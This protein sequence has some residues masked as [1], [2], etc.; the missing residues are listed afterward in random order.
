M[1][2]RALDRDQKNVK[3]SSSPLVVPTQDNGSHIRQESPTKAKFDYVKRKLSWSKA[4]FLH[5]E[6][7]KVPLK[8]QV[9]PNQSL[10]ALYF[11]CEHYLL[12][13]CREVSHAAARA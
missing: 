13:N 6:I 8:S 4:W 2:S 11:I 3:M 5:P 9:R 12:F 10:L 1:F 7:T